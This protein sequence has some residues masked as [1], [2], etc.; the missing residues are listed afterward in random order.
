M[1]IYP[2]LGRQSFNG[3]WVNGVQVKTFVAHL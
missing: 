2:T 1:M 3:L